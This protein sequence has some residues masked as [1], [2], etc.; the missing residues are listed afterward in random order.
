MMNEKSK[1]CMDLLKNA[2]VNNPDMYIS[3]I[4]SMQLT[5]NL[6][7]IEFVHNADGSIKKLRFGFFSSQYFSRIIKEN[8]Y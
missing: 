3:I 1:Y 6:G 5:D 7:A 4:D 8:Y 2:G